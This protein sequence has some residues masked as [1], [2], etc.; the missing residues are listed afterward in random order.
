M[1]DRVKF[2]KGKQREFL[3]KVIENLSCGSLRSVLQYGF[4]TNYNNLKSYYL[5]RRLLPKDLFDNLC[6][7]SKLDVNELNVEFL[8]ENWGQIKGGVKSKRIK[9]KKIV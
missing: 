9:I 5:E 3:K 4:E 7:L 1:V 8:D 6:Y 2:N